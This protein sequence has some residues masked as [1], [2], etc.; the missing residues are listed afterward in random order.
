MGK[1][2]VQETVAADVR[3]ESQGVS[4]V[5]CESSLPSQTS[6]LKGQTFDS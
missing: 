5:T 3:I 6:Y 2:F 1:L 4:K